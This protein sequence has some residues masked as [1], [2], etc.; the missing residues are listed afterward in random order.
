MLIVR[1]K[2]QKPEINIGLP[3][4]KAGFGINVQQV[5]EPTPQNK[6]KTDDFPKLPE[7]KKRNKYAKMVAPTLK[8]EQRVSNVLTINVMQVTKKSM[9]LGD[10]P[11]DRQSMLARMSRVSAWGEDLELRDQLLSEFSTGLEEVGSYHSV[12][13]MLQRLIDRCKKDGKPLSTIQI[14]N[15][16]NFSDRHYLP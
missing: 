9:F 1:R 2:E 12:D 13:K 8:S 11:K 16:W 10:N 3:D 15:L 6:E 7:K 14:E 4:K 5:D